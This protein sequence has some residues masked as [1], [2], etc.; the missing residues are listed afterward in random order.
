MTP[1]LK[2]VAGE[3][4]ETAKTRAR[5]VAPGSGGERR[6]L[7]RIVAWLDVW[8]VSCRSQDMHAWQAKQEVLRHL[9]R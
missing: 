1:A 2:P 8:S 7:R 6:L 9:K 4:Q 5:N 3:L